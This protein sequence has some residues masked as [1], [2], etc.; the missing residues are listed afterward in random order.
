MELTYI[1][2]VN[3]KLLKRNKIVFKRKKD[4]NDLRLPKKKKFK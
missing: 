2:G 1:F 3:A 4:K